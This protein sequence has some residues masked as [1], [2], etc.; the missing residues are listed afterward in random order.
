MRRSGKIIFFVSCLI[1]LVILSITALG[2]DALL[3]GHNPDADY[4][5]TGNLRQAP[6]GVGLFFAPS[7]L[8]LHEN[9]AIEVSVQVTGD[10]MKDKVTGVEVRLNGIVWNE[11]PGNEDL[12]IRIYPNSW[13][14]YTLEG[15]VKVYLLAVVH[16]TEGDIFRTQAFFLTEGDAPCAHL[17]MVF[18][19]DP[20]EGRKFYAQSKKDPYTHYLSKAYMH[21]VCEDC[22]YESLLS[23][24]Q[25]FTED[26]SPI[27]VDHLGEAGQASE[28]IRQ[29]N[30]NPERVYDTARKYPFHSSKTKCSACGA[31]V[32]LWSSE[33]W[34][35]SRLQAVV[36]DDKYYTYNANAEVWKQ[37]YEQ[38]TVD[39]YYTALIADL[40][41]GKD[42]MKD[43]A[44]SDTIANRLFAFGF[45]AN[46]IEDVLETLADAEQP[47]KDLYLLSFY[48]YSMFGNV[49]GDYSFYDYPPNAIIMSD[50]FCS[51]KK[52]EVFTSVFFHE[53]GHA[54]QSCRWDWMTYPYDD[55]IYK[56]SWK[57]IA[58]KGGNVELESAVLEAL[59]EDVSERLTNVAKKI[60]PFLA[61]NVVDLFMDFNDTLEPAI[62]AS[63]ENLVYYPKSIYFDLPMRWIYKDV[64]VEMLKEIED[65]GG[66]RKGGCIMGA[67]IYA[68]ITNSHLY[69]NLGHNNDYWIFTDKDGSKSQNGAQIMEAWAEFFSA[70]IMNDEEAISSNETLFPK[71]TVELEKLAYELRD[72][73]W[74]T[75]SQKY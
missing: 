65:A 68:G 41:A 4:W 8:M 46:N 23:S 7:N 70:K 61:E 28:M 74:Q 12:A 33:G 50:E 69:D 36:K 54:V 60:N 55:N 17:N 20:D 62:N 49:P 35:Q 67:D 31:T 53:S 51:G 13:K 75:Y 34:E 38:E 42:P 18:R 43:P 15:D 45:N 26:N 14:D 9:E 63:D 72:D 39:E 47:Y 30:S 11:Y 27:V 5:W 3:E 44:V 32:T 48:E 6:E 40:R 37:E 64:R 21:Y 10:I 29:M 25:S 59:N 2:E 52:T 71:A 57:E 56:V 24:F 1:L 19:M 16:T 66:R 22:G 73:Y 58:A